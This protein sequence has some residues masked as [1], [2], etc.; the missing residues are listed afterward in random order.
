MNKISLLAG[1]LALAGGAGPKTKIEVSRIKPLS[2]TCNVGEKENSIASAT[3]YIRTVTD[4]IVQFKD[5][6][7]SRVVEVETTECEYAHVWIHK[8][9]SIMVDEK[10]RIWAPCEVKK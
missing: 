10:H 9:G 3:G 6:E 7:P 5:G 2:I 4:E 8:R 1:V